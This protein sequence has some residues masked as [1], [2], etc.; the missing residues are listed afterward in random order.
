VPPSS[1]RS[2]RSETAA[3]DVREESIIQR[4]RMGAAW[5]TIAFTLV[6][7]LLMLVFILQND[8]DVS[9]QLLWADFDVP[10]GVAVLLGMILGG[11]LV[12]LVTA[13]R[14]TQV[15]LAARRHR[16]SHR[17]HAG[18]NADQD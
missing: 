2:T 14:L 7:G 18:P 17:A 10:L 3:G 9:L 6:L 16:R 12:V 15:R 11:L 13:A 5:I 1:E 4:S 8:D